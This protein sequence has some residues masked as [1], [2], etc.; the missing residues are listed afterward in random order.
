MQRH[1]CGKKGQKPP[2]LNRRGNG[3]GLKSAT[4][5]NNLTV[6]TG[7]M[8]FYRTQTAKSAQIW[9]AVWLYR[10]ACKGSFL[11]QKRICRQN[12]PQDSRRKQLQKMPKNSGFWQTGA[13]KRPKKRCG[14]LCW[15]NKRPCGVRMM[16][17]GGKFLQKKPQKPLLKR[18]RA[19]CPEQ[20]K[21]RAGKARGG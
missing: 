15:K 20:Q 12:K 5:K 17:A 19:I 14:R 7:T 9:K 2:P 11:L 8:S 13:E 21:C 6:Q 10:Q 4:P 3:L 18:E 16:T 1:G